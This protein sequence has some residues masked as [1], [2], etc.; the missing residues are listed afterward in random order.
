MMLAE[1]AE[2]WAQRLL[3]R[4]TVFAGSIAQAGIHHNAVADSKCHDLIAD[5]IDH[6]GGVGSQSPRRS[7]RDA[8]Q[9]GNDEQIEMVERRGAHADA[10]VVGAAQLGH[11]EIIA[12]LYAVQP[13]MRRDRECLHEKL[14]G[15]VIFRPSA[16]T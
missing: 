3:A 11:R 16:S 10:H 8:G 5:G 4:A 14:G 6:T 1:D 15:T 12:E 9:A 2:S 13:A 7:D